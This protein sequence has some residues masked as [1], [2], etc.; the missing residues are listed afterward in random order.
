M[1]TIIEKTRR[2]SKNQDVGLKLE[3]AFIVTKAHRSEKKTNSAV[4]IG[5]YVTQK[6]V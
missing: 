3:D 2:A 5:C 4:G 1:S 6:I